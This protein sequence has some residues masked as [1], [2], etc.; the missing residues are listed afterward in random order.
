MRRAL[1]AVRERELHRRTDNAGLLVPTG[2][3]ISGSGKRAHRVDVYH[4]GCP[5]PEGA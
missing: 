3:G 2:N 5:R 4:A 1:R